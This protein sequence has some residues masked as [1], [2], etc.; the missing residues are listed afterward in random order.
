MT[1]RIEQLQ[2]QLRH[3]IIDLD[4]VDATIHLFDPSIELEEIK[5]KPVPPRHHAFRGEISRIVLTTLRNTKRP[6]TCE[7]IAQRV[8]ADRGLNTTDERL[9]RLMA[10]RTGACLRDNRKKGVAQS[11]MGPDRLL[12]WVVAR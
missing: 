10:K 9:V 4:N 5:S 2:D 12:V 11:K 8:I 6:L 3:A 7:E 1:G